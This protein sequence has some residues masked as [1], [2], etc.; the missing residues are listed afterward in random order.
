MIHH[1]DTTREGRFYI[2]D[3]LDELF[4]FALKFDGRFIPNYEEALKGNYVVRINDK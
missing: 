3:N 1:I 2:S 4:A